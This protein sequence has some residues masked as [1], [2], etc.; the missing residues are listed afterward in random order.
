MSPLRMPDLP[1]PTP[2]PMA[3]IISTSRLGYRRILTNRN[4]AVESRS[5][6]L[7]GRS[8]SMDFSSRFDAPMYD[9]SYGGT[10]GQI[11]SRPDYMSPVLPRARYVSQT[12]GRSH[13]G[14][15]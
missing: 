7:G 6:R 11:G 10:F 8:Y 5:P 13:Q 15:V 14:K 4:A 3:N 12:V 9:Q 1:L 2:P